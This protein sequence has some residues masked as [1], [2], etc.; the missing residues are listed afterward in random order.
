MSVR[1]DSKFMAGLTGSRQDPWEKGSDVLEARRW[2]LVT[3]VVIYGDSSR[4][5]RALDEAT[6]IL[7]DSELSIAWRYLHWPFHGPSILSWHPLKST[8]SD[9]CKLADRFTS[10]QEIPEIEK[11][12]AAESHPRKDIIK[13]LHSNELQSL[14]TC[15][16]ARWGTSFPLNSHILPLAL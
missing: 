3:V 5:Q 4:E 7:L 9:E 10:P 12:P 2:Y 13:V 16:R 15:F 14:R 11:P 8:Q 1:V 6:F